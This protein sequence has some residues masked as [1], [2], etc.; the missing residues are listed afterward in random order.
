MNGNFIT[1]SFGWRK[2][3]GGWPTNR[4]RICVT[5][6]FFLVFF[7]FVFF[8]PC[9]RGPM[10]TLFFSI[11]VF[12]FLA[13]FCLSPIVLTKKDAFFSGKIN[14]ILGPHRLRG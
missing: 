6:F 14:C 11:I 10:V 2:I 12:F 1:I 7:F 13:F 4:N 8:F 5:L 3:N 9:T